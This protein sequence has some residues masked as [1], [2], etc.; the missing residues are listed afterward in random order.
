MHLKNLSV[1]SKTTYRLVFTKKANKNFIQSNS[2]RHKIITKK[3]TPM[4]DYYRIIQG[5]KMIVSQCREMFRF[6]KRKPIHKTLT[7]EDFL[8]KQDRFAYGY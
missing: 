8:P 5:V 4:F 1:K 3:S 2:K 6:R 7:I